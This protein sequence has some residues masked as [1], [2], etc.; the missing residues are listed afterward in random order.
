MVYGQDSIPAPKNYASRKLLIG[1]L[2]AAAYAGS[3]IALNEAWYK[4]YPKTSFHTFNDAREWQQVD[5]VGHSWTAYN[6]SRA[7]TA[8]W[9][10]AGYR[11][12]EK[13]KAVWLGSLSGFTYLTV[14][15]FLDAHSAEWGWSW[16]DIGANLFGTGLFAS[17]EFMWNEQKIQFKFSSHKKNYDA[18]LEQRADHLYG[19]GFA[20]RLLKDYNAQTY[21]L[22]CNLASLF[23]KKS[24]PAWL[25][26]S[27]GY[28][29]EGMFG[30]FSNIAY[31]DNGNTIFDGRGIKRYRQ[32]Y[33]APDID[34]TKIRT[35][36]SLLRT[37]FASLNSLKFP[38]PALEFS[39][40][41][42]KLKALAF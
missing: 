4:D 41:R 16:S 19:S 17:Q 37:I 3:L 26:I 42:L 34:L 7:T 13:N 14:I 35:R 23:P 10:W 21:W 8:M 18:S 20:E 24:L 2:S 33:F 5:K 11:G 28:G 27:V 25:N 9:Q 12:S 1:S 15:E 22:S 31:D 40:K 39:N 29:A 30:G 6:T 38:A 32:W 36:S